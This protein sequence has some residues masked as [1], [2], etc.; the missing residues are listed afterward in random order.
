MSGAGLSGCPVRSFLDLDTFAGGM[1]RDRLDAL[2]REHRVLWEADGFATGR[3]LLVLQQAD[4]DHV[5]KSPALFSSGEGPLLDDFP[6]EILADQRQS[7]TFKDPPDHRRHRALVEGAFR[8]QALEERLPQMQAIAAEIVDR[9]IDRGSC[10]F[11]SEV[12]IQLP[13]RVMC[14]VLGVP[15][16]DRQHIVD[17]TDTL[18]MAD[19][20][21]FARDRAEGFMASIAL[22]DYGE[23]LAARE[24]ANPGD[25]LTTRILAAEIDGERLSDRD[26]GRFF[27]NLIVGGIETTRN[28]LSWAM[29]EFWR[30]P[31]Q[32]RMLQADP[33]LV[34]AAV[35]EVLRYRNPV[36]YLRRT[37]TGETEVGGERV[38]AG[39]KLVCLLGSP[40]RDERFFAEPERFDIT[41]P[42]AN[43]RRHYRTFGAGPHFCVGMHQARLNLTVMLGEIARRIDDPQVIG[44]PR[45]ARSIFLDGFKELNLAFKRR[46]H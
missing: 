20:P 19:D 31:E 3:H 29:F 35:E 40:N 24:R 34:D 18:I 9:V 26:F 27:N 45:H 39:D 36:V 33:S 42:P 8:T 1:P 16:A 30:H 46:E 14:M 12:A 32:Y 43:T 10:E 38:A 25:T 22:I 4:I 44:A 6:A 15:D 13:L 11:V 17:L 21:D 2:R 28:T 5:L 23:A 37:A 7:L 41:R